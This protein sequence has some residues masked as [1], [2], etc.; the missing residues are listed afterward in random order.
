MNYLTLYWRFKM[1]VIIIMTSI[2]RPISGR[3]CNAMIITVFHQIE[4]RACNRHLD[5]RR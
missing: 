2:P 4:T 3:L 5:G 1:L